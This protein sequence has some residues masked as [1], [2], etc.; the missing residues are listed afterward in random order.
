MG[1]ILF[2]LLQAKR[3]RKEIPIY[4]EKIGA[5]VPE[6]VSCEEFLLPFSSFALMKKR[7]G[8]ST[9]RRV[10]YPSDFGDVY[11]FFYQYSS[12]PRGAPA[13]SLSCDTVLVCNET[14]G[15][16][17]CFVSNSGLK[18]LA[19]KAVGIESENER[20]ESL[21]K[22]KRRCNL[23]V[24]DAGIMMYFNAYIYPPSAMAELIFE[25]LDLLQEIKDLPYVDGELRTSN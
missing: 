18:R 15:L 7:R 21:L 4:A 8:G 9:G 16:S 23:E 17:N 11:L 2:V 14:F 24:S 20:L 12:A 1:A 5:I 13:G 10:I 6:D 22:G 3:V 19:K 25:F